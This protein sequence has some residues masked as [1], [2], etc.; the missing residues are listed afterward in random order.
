MKR[1]EIEYIAKNIHAKELEL[2][3]LK[4]RLAKV[5]NN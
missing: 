4:G 5:E 2:S 3:E 1:N